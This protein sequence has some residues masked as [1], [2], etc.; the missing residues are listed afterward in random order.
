MSLPCK[1]VQRLMEQTLGS[2]K[3]RVCGAMPSV[4]I[5]AIVSDAFGR[6]AVVSTRCLCHVN[7]L[8]L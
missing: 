1:E 3:Q 5:S 6:L 7:V 2:I 4:H 8:L